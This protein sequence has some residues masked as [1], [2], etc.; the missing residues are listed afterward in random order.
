MKLLGMFLALGVKPAV[1][2]TCAQVTGGG[3]PSTIRAGVSR[4]TEDDIPD[5]GVA[6][7][8]AIAPDDER[9]VEDMIERLK[10]HGQITGESPCPVVD[11]EHP[12]RAGS[13]LEQ[14]AV[15][16]GIK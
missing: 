7:V 14:T 10:D 12:S 11:E 5:V 6:A 15:P 3:R 2:L 4:F 8:H 1:H 16:A 9:V 13:T